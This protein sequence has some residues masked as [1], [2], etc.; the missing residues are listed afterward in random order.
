MRPLSLSDQQLATVM[1]AATR[2]E[3]ERRGIF[4]ERCAAMLRLRG[5]FDD[6]EVVTVV[7]LALAGLA[8]RAA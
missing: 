4:L 7:A 3:P 5:R 8:G 1:Q 2:V 6:K